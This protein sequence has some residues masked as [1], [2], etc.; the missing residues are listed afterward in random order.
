MFLFLFYILLFFPVCQKI[1]NCTV[2]TGSN[3]YFPSIIQECWNPWT[4]SRSSISLLPLF[5]CLSFWMLLTKNLFFLTGQSFFW[6]WTIIGAPKFAISFIFMDIFLEIA[7]DYIYKSYNKEVTDKP[8][9]T[10]ISWEI[11][12]LAGLLLVLQLFG[13]SIST[14]KTSF[15]SSISIYFL[16]LHRK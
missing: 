7:K 14:V 5:W 9:G 10:F 2:I 4:Y 3:I 11:L 6:K 15:F 1:I 12:R 13:F 8:C 16:G